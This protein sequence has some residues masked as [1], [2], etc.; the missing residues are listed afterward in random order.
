VQSTSHA[1]TAASAHTMCSHSPQGSVTFGDS[2]KV[3]Y[4]W[5]KKGLEWSV[6]RSVAALRRRATRPGRRDA[7]V[8]VSPTTPVASCTSE[9]HNKA[10]PTRP[11]RRCRSHTRARTG[12]PAGVRGMTNS[13]NQPGRQRSP[14]I[15]RQTGRRRRRRPRGAV[16]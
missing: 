8:H 6:P 13:S 14:P 1:R 4:T 9:A 16:P 12:C 5:E 10:H 15:R 11:A 3:H 7:R 2:P